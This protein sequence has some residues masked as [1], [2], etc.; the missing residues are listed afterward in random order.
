MNRT[1]NNNLAQTHPEAN[2][3]LLNFMVDLKKMVFIDANYQPF[4]MERLDEWDAHR[5]DINSC[6]DWESSM[7]K[8]LSD[9]VVYEHID[10]VMCFNGLIIDL[11]L[12]ILGHQFRPITPERCDEADKYQAEIWHCKKRQTIFY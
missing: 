12:M 6:F 4:T 7:I 10:A 2:R 5:K 1:R 9:D 11:K 8:H 3:W